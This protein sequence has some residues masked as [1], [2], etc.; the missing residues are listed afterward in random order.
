MTDADD[1]WLMMTDELLQMTD[2]WWT[3]TDF[4]IDADAQ[5]MSIGADE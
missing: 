5:Q 3:L 4:F 1:D 2:D